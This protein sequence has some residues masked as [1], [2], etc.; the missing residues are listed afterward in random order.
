MRA[1]NLI[2]SLPCRTLTSVASNLANLFQY[3]SVPITTQFLKCSLNQLYLPTDSLISKLNTSFDMLI[4]YSYEHNVYNFFKNY[5]LT[6]EMQE[7]NI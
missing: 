6:G 4:L 5:T 7:K 3:S 1:P 2:V